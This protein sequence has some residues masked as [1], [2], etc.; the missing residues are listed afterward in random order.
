MFV[1]V[2]AMELWSWSL[3]PHYM[4]DSIF[5]RFPVATAETIFFFVFVFVFGISKIE[6]FTSKYW[7]NHRSKNMPENWMGVFHSHFTSHLHLLVSHFH[8][9]FFLLSFM[10][11]QDAAE[12]RFNS[13]VQFFSLS[14]SLLLCR[15]F[16]ETI[17]SQTNKMN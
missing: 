2:C 6:S 9:L 10:N 11:Q 15:S 7:T 5:Q 12:I 16:S 13:C 4:F 3:S 1:C 8:S 14:L 17:P